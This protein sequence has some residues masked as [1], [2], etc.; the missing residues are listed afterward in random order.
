MV[1]VLFKCLSHYRKLKSILI[2]EHLVLRPM[3]HGEL[4]AVPVLVLAF[5]L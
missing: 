3:N 5:Q 4:F 1:M 2:F